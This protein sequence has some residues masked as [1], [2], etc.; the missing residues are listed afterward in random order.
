[1]VQFE[2]ILFDLLV[3]H[4][5]VIVPEF[6][7]FVS[8]RVSSKIDFDKGLVIPPSKHL[9]FN[10]HLTTNDGLLLSDYAEKNAIT[11]IQA[12]ENLA[13]LVEGFQKT[14]SEGR[15]VV[16]PRIGSLKRSSEGVFTFRQDKEFNLLADA[17][18]LKE[19]EFVT[20]KVERKLVPKNKQNVDDVAEVTIDI[21]SIRRRK[22]LKYAAAAC[23]LP[24]MF[25]TFW[26]PFKSDFFTSGLISIRDFNPFYKKEVGM[27]A[28][29]TV[30]YKKQG[31][32][33]SVQ[34]IKAPE[35]TLSNPTVRIESSLP[36]KI[37]ETPKEIQIVAAPVVK[38]AYS[39]QFI[40][41]CFSVKKNADNFLIKLQEDGF[42][43]LLIDGGKLQRVSLGLTY[44][45]E[46]FAALVALAKKRG[47]TGWTLK[48]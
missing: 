38:I 22:I 23:L 21:K 35:K 40:V 24:F 20:V 34:E 41:G 46:D 2:L 8:K 14:L 30:V 32:A 9:L 48:Q 43:P 26:I 7:G 18:G 31:T 28:P 17:F 44:S 6:G 47:Y 10:K 33:E 16:F 29:S 15:E 3:R 25:Y 36:E 37:I 39:K 12:E 1:M 42:S 13:K 19:L 11:Y 45:K 4:N 5:C 27:Y